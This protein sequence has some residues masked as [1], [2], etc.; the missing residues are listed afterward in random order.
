MMGWSLKGFPFVAKFHK[1]GKK[2]GGGGEGEVQVGLVQRIDY[3]GKKIHQN[4][5][6]LRRAKKI[7]NKKRVHTYSH[8]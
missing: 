1:W 6:I 8:I 5:H 7:K 2:V 3:F 4:H